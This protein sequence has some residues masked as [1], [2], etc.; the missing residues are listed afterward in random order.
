M[1]T[2]LCE[3]HKVVFSY[4]FALNRVLILVIQ[5]GDSF[6]KSSGFIQNYIGQGVIGATLLLVFREEFLLEV[7]AEEIIEHI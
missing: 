4:L 2:G 5:K 1:A 7:G 3:W 6:W